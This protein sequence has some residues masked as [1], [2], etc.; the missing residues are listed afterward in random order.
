MMQVTYQ[1]G[2]SIHSNYAVDFMM[3]ADPIEGIDD[4][5]DA[6]LYA[7]AKIEYED[8]DEDNNETNEADERHYSQLKAEV[9]EKAERLGIDVSQLHFFWD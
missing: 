1:S 6:H 2:E 9:I 3:V 4:W 8:V 7:E 5:E